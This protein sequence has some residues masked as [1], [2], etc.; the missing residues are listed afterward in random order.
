MS[1]LLTGNK[2]VIMPRFDAR[3]ALELI[4]RHPG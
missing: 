4:G 3:Q 2:M 1:A